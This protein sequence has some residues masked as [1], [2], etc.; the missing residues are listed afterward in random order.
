MSSLFKIVALGT[1]A[2]V[3]M[4]ASAMPVG[5]RIAMMQSRDVAQNPKVFVYFDL[6][7]G[8]GG[9]LKPLAF[10]VNTI[11]SLPKFTSVKDGYVFAGWSHTP[12]GGKVWNDQQQIIIDHEVVLSAY[13]IW[14]RPNCYG[15]AF[16]PGVENAEW[17]MGY[18]SVGV[19]KVAKLNPC[20]FT[21][22]AGKRFAGW[23]RK[24]T[25]RRYDD[26]VMVFN[27]ASESGAVVVLEA[28]WEDIP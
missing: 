26:G 13:A 6:M 9:A 14:L 22:P 2:L 5:L 18:Q 16:D 4:S 28:V 3:G 10:D 27:L 15:I 17:S 25:G 21:P 8:A 1:L 24:G 12:N 11:A 19:G 20:A 7:G 23:R